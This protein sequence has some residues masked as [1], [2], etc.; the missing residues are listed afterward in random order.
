[1]PQVSAENGTTR[2]PGAQVVTP[3]PTATTS[4][5]ASAPTVSGVQAL[6]EGHAAEAPDVDVVQPDGADAKLH[7]ARAGRRRGLTLDQAT[8]RSASSCRARMVDMEGV[9]C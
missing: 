3:S 1:M 9:R 4:P 7:L 8:S 5:A 6:G 2:S